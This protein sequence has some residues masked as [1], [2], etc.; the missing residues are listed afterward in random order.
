MHAVIKKNHLI[1]KQILQKKV[2]VL[3]LEILSV[4]QIKCADSK[5]LYFG[6]IQNRNML[7]IINFIY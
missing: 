7:S 4:P 3:L 6:L 1:E 2:N 5:I